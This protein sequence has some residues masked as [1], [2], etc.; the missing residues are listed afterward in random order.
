MNNTYKKNKNM[1]TREARKYTKD[2]IKQIINELVIK[3]KT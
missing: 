3:L 2:F 1:L